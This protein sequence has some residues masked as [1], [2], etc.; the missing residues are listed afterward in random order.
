MASMQ[1]LAAAKTPLEFVE[2]Q[3]KLLTD[4]VATA[5]SD[6]TT[7][8]KLATEAF[9]AAFEAVRKQIDGLQDVLKR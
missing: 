1:A 5:I 8:G 3:R 4:C 6:G 9:T 7:I 2:L